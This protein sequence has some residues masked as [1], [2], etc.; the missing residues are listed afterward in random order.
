M[1][2][3]HIQWAGDDGHGVAWAPEWVHK[4]FVDQCDELRETYWESV[5]RSELDQTRLQVV[6]HPLL[7]PVW[8]ICI[9]I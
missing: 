6:L 2:H 1:T 7:R 5:P 8:M 9:I 4:G 3:Y